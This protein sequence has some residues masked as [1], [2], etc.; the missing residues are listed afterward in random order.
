ML[1]FDVADDLFQHVLDGHQ[2]RHTAVLVDDD[3]HVIV[4]G[5]ELAQQHVQALGLGHEGGRAQQ[6][7]DVEAVAVL[8]EDQ[9]QQVFGQQHAKDIVMAFAN[10]RVARVRSVDHSWEELAWRLRGLDADH[11]RARHHDVA[12]LQVGD[13]NGAFDDGQRF[14]VEQLVLMGFAQQLKQLLAVFRL[15]GKSLGQF[16]QPGLLPVARSIFA[17]GGYS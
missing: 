6:V 2:A 15:M 4:V 13:L 14:A 9:R 8:F 10:H 16:A 11:L 3:G 12:Y 7:L 1:V 5:A 17:H